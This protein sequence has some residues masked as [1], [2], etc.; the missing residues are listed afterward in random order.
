MKKIILSIITILA[1]YSIIS[2][3]KFD[4]FVVGYKNG[5]PV[6]FSYACADVCTPFAPWAWET[7]YYGKISYDECIAMN[8]KPRLVGLVGM[9]VNGRP[10]D[11]GLGGYAGCKPK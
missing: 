10:L 4:G 1:V 5:Y 11:T 8:D 9:D 7:Q 3:Y 6:I 2:Y